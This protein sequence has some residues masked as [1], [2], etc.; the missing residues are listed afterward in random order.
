MV[1]GGKGALESFDALV[2]QGLIATDEFAQHVCVAQLFPQPAQRI[3]IEYWGSGH[4][5][6]MLPLPQDRAGLSPKL[7]SRTRP[8]RPPKGNLKIGTGSL[9]ESLW[10]S[11]V[12][13][14]G[15]LEDE[16]LK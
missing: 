7:C 11:D 5:P 10:R 13:P 9:R 15:H 8:V 14:E 6:M 3:S 16:G 12:N 2:Q 4:G 1:L